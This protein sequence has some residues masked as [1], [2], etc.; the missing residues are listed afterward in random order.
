MIAL[1]T[2]KTRLLPLLFVILACLPCWAAPD[3]EPDTQAAVTQEPDPTQPPE[4]QT[5]PEQSQSTKAGEK[6]QP[7]KSSSNAGNLTFKPSE[8]I[9]EDFSVPFP[10]DI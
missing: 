3:G 7:K 4:A 10:V 8:Q 2:P 1:V 5:L 6:P 9:S